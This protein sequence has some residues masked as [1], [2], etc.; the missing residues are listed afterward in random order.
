MIEHLSLSVI[1]RF[2]ERSGINAQNLSIIK[3]AARF[4][5]VDSAQAVPM[6]STSSQNDGV[7]DA[8]ISQL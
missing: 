7:I 8:F 2:M 6:H 3:D 4:K 1:L 5:L